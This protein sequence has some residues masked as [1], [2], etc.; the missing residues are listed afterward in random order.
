[1]RNILGVPA[2]FLIVG[3]S[4][5]VGSAAEKKV[6]PKEGVVL[7]VNGKNSHITFDA[8]DGERRGLKTKGVYE[9]A[10][11]SHTIR[12]RYYFRRGNTEWT[13]NEFVDYEFTG[14]AGTVLQVVCDET[15]TGDKGTWRMWLQDTASGMDVRRQAQVMA[16][17]ADQKEHEEQLVRNF[18]ET[19]Q[20]AETGELEAQY[21]VATMYEQGQGTAPDPAAA[22]RW[23]VKAGERGHS[24]AL[25]M[26]GLAYDGGKGV[27]QDPAE[28]FVWFSLAATFGD[29]S[30][31]YF[32]DEGEQTLA[33]DALAKARA[34][35][36]RLA[37]EIRA[38]IPA[39]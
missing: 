30:A 26:L 25:F 20:K 14:A 11:G 19:L 35:A 33:P 24:V 34:K 6:M 8:I 13:S 37:A 18:A 38:R 21:E 3:C 15:Q 23:Y 31:P 4:G 27:E 39:A 12:A 5:V 17:Q 7:V 10:P 28:A 29:T 36:E 16:A 2:L 9:L 1:M 32:R 22:I